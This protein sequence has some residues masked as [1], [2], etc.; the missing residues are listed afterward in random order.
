VLIEIIASKHGKIDDTTMATALG[1][2]YD[3]GLKP[4]WWKL[5]AQPSATAWAA[6]DTMIATRDPLCRGVVLLGLDAPQDVL[7]QGFKA[8]RSAGVVK[9]F[10]VGRTIFG[11]AARAWLA[12]TMNDEQAVDDMAQRFEALTRIWQR[13]G[14][15]A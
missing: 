6:I 14:G 3:A 13:A 7:E 1:E 5:E 12:G 4:D 9:G 8:A 15:Q 2:L 10:A 11:G